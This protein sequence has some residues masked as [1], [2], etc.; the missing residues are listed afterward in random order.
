MGEVQ[1]ECVALFE[2]KCDILYQEPITWGL[3]L[4]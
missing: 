1:V 4:S 3:Q 2:A